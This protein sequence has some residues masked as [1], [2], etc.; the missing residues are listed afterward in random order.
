[1][2][3][4]EVTDEI[5]RPRVARVTL[6][7]ELDLANAYAFD[8][9]LLAIEQTQPK[10]I[11]VDLRGLTMLDSAGLARLVSAQRRARRGGW[12][13]VLVRGGRAIQRVLQMTQLDEH[14]DIARDLPRAL[15]EPEA[16]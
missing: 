5:V 9:R 4:F 1:M 6:T 2:A 14:F 7:G 8:R 16:G 12:K 3:P 10:L 15:G 11:V 13:L